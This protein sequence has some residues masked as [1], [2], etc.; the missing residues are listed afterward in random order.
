MYAHG[1][2]RVNINTADVERLTIALPGIGPVKAQA[3]VTY[4]ETY[5]PF[6]SVE[7]LLDVPGIGPVTMEALRPL[8][9]V[10]DEGDTVAPGSGLVP[11]STST[12]EFRLTAA[13]REQLARA[14]VRSAV[15][16][17][18]RSVAL[19]RELTLRGRD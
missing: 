8:V 4:R 19:Q 5:G 3:I 10:S 7:Q 15:A 16:K 17:A 2:Q 12:E 6:T 1:L 18:Y 9:T 11:S 14:A 13:Q